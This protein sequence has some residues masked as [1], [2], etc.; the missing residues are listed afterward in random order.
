MKV[1][2]K[3]LLRD[4]ELFELSFALKDCRKKTMPVIVLEENKTDFLTLPNT[5]DNFNGC[6]ER[7]D[8]LSQYV[9]RLRIISYLPQEILQ[10]VKDK[11]LLA[12]GY[13]EQDVKKAILDYAK[14]KIYF[15]NSLT[16]VSLEDSIDNTVGLT[17]ER[18]FEKH[19]QFCSVE[20]LFDG[21][22]IISVCK[23]A[24]DLYIKLD[25]KETIAL[26]SVE[27]LEEEIKPD[28]TF[29]QLFEL[30]KVKRKYELH[31]L[32]MTKDSDLIKHFHYV[33]YRFKDMRYV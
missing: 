25:N 28:D 7:D 8:I 5:F 15:A 32:L 31:F 14:D 1:L 3:E 2:T 27:T 9:N 6:I 19:A 22:K 12:L 23:Q 21:V 16:S 33:T 30:H 20:E 18:Q 29:V 4:M 10:R 26:T 17:I 24:K 13:A 11:R